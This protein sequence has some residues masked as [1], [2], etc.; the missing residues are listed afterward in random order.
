MKKKLLVILGAGSSIPVGMP[1]VGAIDRLMAGWSS[2]SAKRHGLDDSFWATWKAIEDYY[3][4]SPDSIRPN[5][6]F[7]KVLGE[8]VGLAHWMTPSPLGHALRQ[9]IAPTGQPLGMSFEPSPYAVT[10]SV[11][12]QVTDLLVELARHMRGLSDPAKLGSHPAFPGYRALMEALRARFDIGIFNLNYDTA[13]L[14]AFAGAFTGFAA[15]GSF[16]PDGVHERTEWGFAYHLHGSVHHSLVHRFGNSLRWQPDLSADFFD[17]H[18]GNSTDKRSDNR[19]IPKTTLIAGG[20][21]LDQLLTEPFHSFYASLI[22][23]TYEADAILI[24]GYGFGDMHVNRA[25]QNRLDPT[26][27]RPPV[28]VLTRAPEPDPVRK[29]YP[30]PMAF[31]GDWWAK[32]LSISLN[33]PNGFAEPGH[34]APPDITDLIARDGFEV[35]SLHRVAIWHGGFV[36][37]TRR[38]DAILPWLEG[39]AADSILAGAGAP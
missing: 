20:F 36:E 26:K 14:T 22:R 25:L 8:M 1:S 6:N 31:R 21:K 7:E 10:V 3:A 28:L 32:Y 17:G 18:P 15:D 9:I 33:A 34:A 39:T 37:A 19:A 11:I 23:R 35:S 38:L 12:Q 16:D 13:A 2:A 30:D 5:P 24:G 4:A 27:P 29:I